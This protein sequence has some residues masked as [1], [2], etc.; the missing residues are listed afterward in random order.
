MTE[1]KRNTGRLIFCLVLMAAVFLIFIA[2]LFQWQILEGEKFAEI[3]RSSS[4][5]FV[6]LE[7]TRGEI[8]DRNGVLLAG[9]IM[10][11][12]VKLNRLG[13]DSPNPNSTII[14]VLNILETRGEE[15]KDVLPIKIDGNGTYYFDEEEEAEIAYLKSD[16]VLG[17]QEYATAEHCMN[18]LIK[19]YDATGYSIEDTRDLLSVRYSMHIGNFSRTTPY[20][21]ADGLSA[22]TVGVINEM[23]SE[24]PG[25]ETGLS[26][27]RF[28]GEDGTVAPHTIGAIGAISP[29]MYEAAKE[30]GNTY[31]IDNVSGYTMNDTAGRGGIEK[32]YEDVLRGENGKQT[33]VMDT[34]GNVV[35]TNT[36]L[37]PEAGNT[38]VLTLDAKIQK[39]TNESLEKNVVENEESELA[40]VGSAVMID[41]KDFGVLA[42]STY[43]SYDLNKYYEDF[44]Y[45]K[46][47]EADEDMPLFNRALDG[48]YPPGSAFKPLVALAALQ[49]NIIST[50]ETVYCDGFYHYYEDVG[51]MP[52]CLDHHSSVN[53]YS[54]LTHSCNIYFYD[55][56]RRLGIGKMA[57][58]AEYFGLGTYTGVEIGEARGRMS[59]PTEYEAIRGEPWVDGNTVTAAIGQLDDNFTALQLATYAA[60][61]ANGGKRL[62]T[63]FMKEIVDYDRENVIEAYQPTE[64]MDAQ[65]SPW[66]IDYIKDAM[67]NV[68]ENGS[69]RHVFQDYEI[70]ICSKTGTAEAPEANTPDH[71]TFI[72][73]APKENPEV[74]VAVIMEHGQ[75]S[76]LYAM[77]VA[78]DMLDAYFGLER[79]EDGNLIDE[80]ENAEA[81][82]S[83][84]ASP[85]P[86]PQHPQGEDANVGAFYDPEKD[87]PKPSPSGDDDASND[88]TSS[89]GDEG[90]E[91]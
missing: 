6:K 69:G 16:E 46:G 49:E 35:N 40:K 55:V 62:K 8:L 37:V 79:D 33:I 63:H 66:I 42:S 22:E 47:L 7:A 58:Y 44:E 34:D 28:Y 80:D 85:S 57:P 13:M 5:D 32:A 89:E 64:M 36:T 26:Q 38:V 21:I 83:P 17:L 68:G 71:L 76:G 41:V 70:E 3:S 86:M 61:I 90:G 1:K 52:T 74:A 73:F 4:T 11:Y 54:A 29:D 51:F 12:S 60:T 87:I 59:N 84:S 10:G 78:K 48:A 25:I 50:D 23:K 24:L 39:V 19:R 88:E 15:W 43:P 67:R 31:S 2:R 91:E 75:K 18:A 9:N 81:S 77:N 27:T 20:T 65:I 45:Y 14:K 56:G 72:A 30:Q 82:A 53:M